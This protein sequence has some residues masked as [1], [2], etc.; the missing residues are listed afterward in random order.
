M[1]LAGDIGG[2]KVNICRISPEQGWTPQDV[3]TYASKD[4]DGLEQILALYTK[5][6]EETFEMACFGIAGAVIDGVCETTNLPWIVETSKL[7]DFLNIKQVH[8]IND[9][10]AA[11][12]A[13]PILDEGN[14]FA[15]HQA[16]VN[17][18]GAIGLISAGTGLGMAL[19]LKNGDQYRPVSSEGGH[20]DYAPTNKLEIELL[21][22]L[23]KKYP[24]VSCEN[25][26]SGSGICNI[27]AF[28]RD[29]GQTCED[30]AVLA[31]IDSA[32]HPA[33]VISKYALAGTS[34]LCKE[35]IRM[36]V[37]IYG[38]IAG[39][40]ALTG[41]TTG[42]LYIGGGIAAKNF[43]LF[44]DGNF[45]NAFKAKGRMEGFVSNVEVKLITDE[46]TGLLGAA[47]YAYLQNRG[48]VIH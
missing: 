45:T 11:I 10:V 21:E 19:L 30:E 43:E 7:K 18:S 20:A 32:E 36:F 6:V 17:P 14:C 42:G 39:N 27:Y 48:L 29:K 44:K 25:L 40:L 35:V 12:M 31:E 8:L 28:L 34:K 1:I 38:A 24:R 3:K 46:Q 33:A 4:F 13:I 15:L 37:D 9:L 26:L 2:T 22:F 41:M 47:H 16:K 23:R 5:E